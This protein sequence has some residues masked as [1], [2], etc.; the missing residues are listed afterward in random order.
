MMAFTLFSLMQTRS[1]MLVYAFT[2]LLCLP[3]TYSKFCDESILHES[4]TLDEV[5]SLSLQFLLVRTDR[6]WNFLGLLP[7]CQRGAWSTSKFWWFVNENQTTKDRADSAL[8]W[9]ELSWFSFS[10]LKGQNL[11]Q[12]PEEVRYCGRGQQIG[13][14][15]NARPARRSTILFD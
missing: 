8:W 13:C 1:V 9:N 2:L 11:A 7:V 14:D 12:L 3:K 5:S 10:F 4:H 15:P 6:S